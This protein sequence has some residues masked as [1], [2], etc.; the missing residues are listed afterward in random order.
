MIGKI[1]KEIKEVTIVGGGIAGLLAAYQLDKAGYQVVLKEAS[2]QL[3]GLIKTTTTDFGLSEAAAHSLLTSTA[4]CQLF[5]ELNIPLLSVNSDSKA[6]YIYR[7]NKMRKLPLSFLEA[8]QTA[9]KVFGYHA[10]E[11]DQDPH[12]DLQT[13]GES[14]LGQAASDYLLSPFVLGVYGAKTTNLN[15]RAAMPFLQVPVGQSLFAHLRHYRKQKKAQGDRH[16]AKMVVPA[17]GMSALV[18][19]IKEKLEQSPRATIELGCE[20][21]EIESIDSNLILAVPVYEAAKLLAGQDASLAH[22]LNQISYSKIVSATVY[23]AQKNFP[24]AVKGVGVLIPPQEKRAILGILFNSS[25]FS[26]RVNSPD[27][28]SFTVMLGGDLSPQMVDYDDEQI[29]Q[30]IASELKTIL[31]MQADPLI[32]VIHRQ[33]Q[34]IPHYNGQLLAMWQQAQKGWCQQPGHVLFSNYTHQVSLR[35]MIEDSFAFT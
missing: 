2:A 31:G 6:R 15:V 12:Q 22:S 23:V 26:N 3:G 16:K 8:I 9:Y 29:Q 10:Q 25:S 4:V 35:G 34:A 28:A 24:Q 7:S 20:V 19:A 17:G 5:D 30:I 33:P 1:N 18:S 13:W 27:W 21:K 32:Y 11:K 14:F